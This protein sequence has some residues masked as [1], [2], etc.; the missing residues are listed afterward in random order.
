MTA[1][2]LMREGLLLDYITTRF[3]RSVLKWLGFC[4]LFTLI[5]FFYGSLFFFSDLLQE[6]ADIWLEDA[7]DIVV[8]MQRGGRQ[9]EMD[10]AML[11]TLR[12]I[13]GVADGRSRLW[14]YYY[15]AA[16]RSA[17][18]VIAPESTLQQGEAIVGRGVAALWQFSAGDSI[19]LEDGN[20]DSM[21]FRI[22][23]V[24]PEESD[25]VTADLFQI[26]PAD[27]RRL[28][29]LPENLVTD[30]A[31]SVPQPAERANVAAK[32]KES[33]P[34]SRVVVKEDLHNT[35]RMIFGWR[36]A[37]FLIISVVGLLALLIFAIDQ[38]SGLWS[39]ER[40]EIALLRCLGWTPGLVIR[41]RFYE[42][43]FIAL[44]S[45]LT[46]TLLAWCHIYLLGG[47]LVASV[48]RGWSAIFP[49]AGFYPMLNLESVG[50]L[51]CITV[52][53]LLSVALIPIWKT[54]NIDPEA[55]K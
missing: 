40:Q 7:P 20:G 21:V 5:T 19:S 34:R 39:G 27:F 51:F 33:F 38:L 29:Q 50:Y 48:L 45:W 30:L 37:I 25:L 36:S 22:H 28:F 18:T 15:D 47:G 11:E 9:Q 54:A 6:Q 17:Y 55:L 23:S 35:Y 53:P 32:I 41:A 42:V 16:T 49:Q 24:F 46:G 43:G 31:L 44:F 10:P 12:E 8:Q 4:F 1:H 52:V 3:R 13:R 2:F 14:G 26:T